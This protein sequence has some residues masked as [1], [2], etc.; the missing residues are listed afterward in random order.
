MDS[1]T[2]LMREKVLLYDGSKG[3]MLQKKGLRGDEAAEYWNITK[4]DIVRQIHEMYRQA[5]SD[6]L[7]TNTFPGNRAT[8][9][10]HGLGDQVY[11]INY[12]GVKLAK[13][14][15]GGARYI[16]AS[17]GPTGRLYEPAGDLT[18]DGAYDIFREQVKAIADAGADFINAETFMDLSEMRAAIIAAKENSRLP[19]IAALTFEK[20]SRTLFG[21]P[22][23][24][25]AIVCHSLGAAATGANCSSGPEGLLE[26]IKK[27]RSVVAA[28]LIAKA[29]A[30][31]PALVGGAA[32]YN[33]T[34][35]QFSRY[36]REFV[37]QG[38]R[39]IGGCCGTT[40]EYIAALRKELERIVAP[41]PV[42]EENYAIASGFAYIGDMRKQSLLSTTAPLYEGG[43]AEALDNEDI[44]GAVD[45]LLE[46]ESE[47]SDYLLL[48][49]GPLA[50]AFNARDF[51]VQIGGAIRKPIVIKTVSAE[52]KEVF[53][54][55]Y[56]GRAGV[57]V[58]NPEAISQEELRYGALPLNTERK[59]IMIK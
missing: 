14:A 25:C 30:G 24:A 27:M 36:A 19:V 54:R 8:L 42:W 18:F 35:E 33:E 51:A 49:F 55:Y 15:A 10:K 11:R 6:V 38:V 39:L 7:Q 21:N 23:E 56:P 34:P 3:F 59:P 13:E 48:D 29:N 41:E 12:E 46:Y 58:D 1:L 32:V 31:I 22:A 9:G 53:L 45:I 20:S 37:D 17:I 50:P 43:L 47:Q 4:P 52:L 5:G 44:D 2:R 57:I 40:P 16:A 26:P 28:P